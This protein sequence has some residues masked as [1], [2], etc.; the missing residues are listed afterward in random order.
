MVRFPIE[1]CLWGT[2]NE[3][4]DAVRWSA[5]AC[6]HNPCMCQRVKLHLF[7]FV[8]NISS[9][10]HGFA[11]PA[12]IPATT[13]GPIP[14]TDRR[15]LLQLLLKPSLSSLS[16]SSIFFSAIDK[17]PVFP[18]VRLSLLSSPRWIWGRPS[19][20]AL[21]V[22]R[23]GTPD[24]YNNTNTPNG[25]V[26]HLHLF[27]LLFSPCGFLPPFESITGPLLF[28]HTLNILGES[29]GFLK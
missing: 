11:S 1:I 13:P 22:K 12:F 2:I 8:F 5:D 6:A 21:A 3:T 4:E 29:P 19:N 26:K 27:R 14:T 16:S 28:K 15:R 10:S 24:P 23:G 9:T 18:C 17:A 7:V 20:P 25:L